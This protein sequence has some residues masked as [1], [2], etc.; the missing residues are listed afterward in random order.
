MGPSL[1]ERPASALKKCVSKEQNRS[2]VSGGSAPSSKKGKANQNHRTLKKAGPQ[3]KHVTPHQ[4]KDPAQAE[5]GTQKRGNRAKPVSTSFA[6]SSPLLPGGRTWPPGA[7]E[8][9]QGVSASTVSNKGRDNGESTVESPGSGRNRPK[10]SLPLAPG[11]SEP[12]PVLTERQQVPSIETLQLYEGEAEDADSASDLSDSERLPVPPSPCSPPQ[13]HLRA[14]VIDPNDL[15]PYFPGP[16]GN[17]SGYSYPD[18]LPP[19]FNTWSLRQLALFLNTEGRCA[20][21]PQ[22]VGQLEKYLERLLQLEWL[23]IQTVEVEIGKTTT[24]AS[25]TASAPASRPRPHTAPAWYLSSPKSIRQCQRAFPTAFLS[26]LGN[27]SA[28][29][30]SRAACPHC[31]VR[32]PFCNGSCR[33]YAYQRH[34]RL[35]PVQQR[36]GGLEDAQKRCSSET[37]AA[38]NRGRGAQ[39]QGQKPGNPSPPNSYLRR[40]QST[41]NIRNPT[42]LADT[43][44]KPQAAQRNGGV[45]STAGR[46]GRRRG[47]AVGKAGDVESGVSLG[48]RGNVHEGSPLRKGGNERQRAP[49][50]VS[51]QDIKP[52][53]SLVGRREPPPVS[54][55]PPCAMSNGKVKRVQF[56]TI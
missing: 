55:G 47:P 23:Q 51:G 1:Q 19:P 43:T 36:G 46:N 45:G 21:R 25:A 41:G 2:K 37:R 48:T 6:E 40:M 31:R 54:K 3:P 20:H 14:E 35:N 18:S 28:P 56:L 30:L 13:L 39:T 12:C 42:P 17:Q 34:S 29:R 52:G 10:M 24:P 49:V 26:C 15:D 32:Y 7:T 5:R 33:S 27:G 16:R 44:A 50:G 4:G 11:A 53:G 8:L 9:K 38:V 22:P